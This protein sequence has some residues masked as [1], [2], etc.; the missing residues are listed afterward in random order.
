MKGMRGWVVHMLPL[1]IQSSYSKNL[2]YSYLKEEEEEEAL[3]LSQVVPF[4]LR[5]IITITR[6]PFA[7]PL[8]CHFSSD[9]AYLQVS[10]PLSPLI[11]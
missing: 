8:Q 3:T 10:H 1:S 6:M 7:F 2:Q 5:I 11:L 4:P 9:L